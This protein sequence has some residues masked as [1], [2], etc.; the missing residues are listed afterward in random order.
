MSLPKI[1]VI[2]P[3]YNSGKYLKDTI[4]SLLKQT[5]NNV[6]IILVD[7][8]SVDGSGELCDK[9][10]Q[11]NEQ[12]VVIHQPNSGVSVARNNGMKKATGSLV[13]FC[14]SDDW[15]DLDYYEFL[16]KQM[17]DSNSDIACCVSDVIT[18][19]NSFRTRLA[20]EKKV[21]DSDGYL[22]SLFRWQVPMS[23]Y[24][25]LYK[26]EVLEGVEFPEDCKINEDKFFC[27]LTGLNAKRVSFEGVGKYHYIRRQGSSSITDFSEKYL[28]GVKLAQRTLDIIKELRPELI[29]EALCNQLLSYMRIYKLIHM[30]NGLKKFSSDA[31]KLYRYIK[32]FDKRLAKKHLVKN[33][34]I[35]YMVAKTGKL[36]FRLFTKFV[37]KS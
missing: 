37:D 17:T 3:V 15:V 32:G 8:G 14:D 31:D 2:V 16:Y 6:E 35:R 13:T 21:W 36:P 5:Y 26:K 30:R 7:D 34:Y 18:A 20:G 10:A 12:V 22:T 19:D 4:E 28:D 25:K 33:D 29:E 11:E 23:V 27:F 1:S 9:Y 24:T